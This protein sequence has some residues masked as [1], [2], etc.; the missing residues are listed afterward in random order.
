[1]VC[2]MHTISR[3]GELFGGCSVSRESL[4]HSAPQTAQLASSY[5]PSIY[6]CEND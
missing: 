4:R 2:A 6:F 3:F 5:Q 1:M